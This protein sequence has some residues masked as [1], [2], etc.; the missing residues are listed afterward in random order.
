LEN[1]LI[2][3]SSLNEGQSIPVSDGI[4]YHMVEIVKLEPS[5]SVYTYRERDQYLDLAISFETCVDMEDEIKE[6]KNE[7]FEKIDPK[8][9][10]FKDIK[11]EDKIEIIEEIKEEIIDGIPCQFCRKIVPENGMKMHSLHCQRNNY[12]CKTCDTVVKV[13]EQKNHEENEHLK[14]KSCD[15]IYFKFGNHEKNCSKNTMLCGFCEEKIP[16]F[17]IE[18]H[19]KECGEKIEHCE[20][21]GED[22]ERKNF[23]HH[24]CELEPY[25]PCS[26][27]YCPKQNLSKDA[28]IKHVLKKHPLDPENL[29][30]TLQFM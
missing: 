7:I 12:I 4:H 26:C 1:S 9:S 29:I 16:K 14:C 6:E 25:G 21:C 15:S 19:V 2:P 28:M 30:G 20:Q 11:R 13:K 24:E 10:L 27:F 17:N 5:M 3:I 8:D 18:K 22:V 23:S